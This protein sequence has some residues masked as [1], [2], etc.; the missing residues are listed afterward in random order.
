MGTRRL[1]YATDYSYYRTLIAQCPGGAGFL[2][3][4][5]H[6]YSQGTVPEVRLSLSQLEHKQRKGR[7][8]GRK[9]K[10]HTTRRGSGGPKNDR[11]R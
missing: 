4:V 6:G 9:S 3:R 5:E 11:L 8:K 1:D 2:T 10:V 7:G